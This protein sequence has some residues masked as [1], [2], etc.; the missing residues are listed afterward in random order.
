MEPT[1]QSPPANPPANPPDQAESRTKPLPATERDFRSRPSRTSSPGFRIAILIGVVVLLVVGFFV[2][3]YVTS[4]ESTDDAEVDGHIN[5]ISARISGHVIKLNVLDNQYVQAGTVLVEIDP[6]DYQVAYERAKADFDDSQAQAA[7]A[8]VN[9]PITSVNTTSQVSATEADVA[10]ARA[11]IAAA[12][13]QFE[14]AKAQLAQAVANDVKAQNDLG[15]YKQLVEKQEISQQQ[16]DQAVAASKA[17]SAA[18]DAA[19]ANADA[20]QSQVTQAQGKLVQAEANLS[21]ARTAPRQMEVSRSRAASALAE[22]QLKKAALDQAALNLQY[23]KITAPVAGVVSDRTVEVGQNVAPGQELMKVIPLN[24]VWITANFKETQLREMKVGQPVTLEVDASGR[25][26]KGKVDSIAGASGARFSLLP[27][28]NATGNY[29]KVVQRIPVKIVLD[30]G[31]NNDQSLRPG[32]SVE[33]KV[34]T[35]Q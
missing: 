33:P 31:E 11:G 29:V 32:M 14:A 23:T 27:P 6:A 25:K 34:W 2:Y 15:R 10:S 8:G 30:P 13:Q 21:Y 35:R 26:Y 19:S 3:R 24:D 1:T 4:Y 12:R 22:V 7:A 16:Y 5:S 17:S 9:V 18:V 20:A 28:E